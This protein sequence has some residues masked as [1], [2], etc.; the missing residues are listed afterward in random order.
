MQL[1]DLMHRMETG[2]DTAK[3]EFFEAVYDTLHRQAQ[4]YMRRQSRQHTLWVTDV[5]HGAYAKMCG[6]S[7]MH[8]ND[9]H[10]FFSVAAKAMEQLLVDHARGKGRQKRTPLGKREALDDLQAAF[11]ATILTKTANILDV[12]EALGVLEQ[13]APRPADIARQK[14][15]GQLSMDRIGTGL[16]IPKRTVEREW[17][18]AREWLRM[19]LKSHGRRI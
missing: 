10:H 5:V 15:F 14:F 1:T 8:W 17:A 6:G 2:D 4:G 16:G 7:S 11:E 13:F 19:W 12:H 18:F 3:N 9:R